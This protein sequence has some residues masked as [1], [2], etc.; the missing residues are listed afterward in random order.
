MTTL[1]K[2]LLFE[3]GTEELPP[4]SLARLA[5]ALADAIRQGL[6][7]QELEH[8]ECTWYATPRRL[9]VMVRD[10]AP[11]QADKHVTRRGPA[12]TAAYDEDGNP[13]K[14]AQGFARSCGVTAPE[15][16]RLDTDKGSWLAYRSL[17]QGAGVADLLP[18]IITKALAGLPIARRMRW[19]DHEVEFVRPVH[20]VVLLFGEDIIPAT[21]LGVAT[22]RET[23]GHRFHHPQALSLDN[24]GQ[25]LTR[26]RDE[27][28]VV[29]DF[30][31]R[32]HQ[33]RQAVTDIART[34]GGRAL[35][36]E[37]LLD[38]VTALV[39]WPVAVIGSFDAEFLNLPQEA[40]IA[41]MQSHQKYFPVQDPATGGLTASFITIANID[42]AD[43]DAVRRGNERV[44]RPRLS[45]A[46][47]FWER[48]RAR[49]QIHATSA[50]PV[51]VSQPPA[52]SDKAPLEYLG[53]TDKV[54]FQQQL[55]TL[56]DKTA[57][58]ASLG[59]YIA[60]QLGFAPDL[61]ARASR[62]AKCDLLSAMVGEFPELQGTM[63]RYYA[64][65]SGEPPAVAL[66]L[67]EQY[68]PR[69]A[70]AALPQTDTGRALALAD[71]LDTLTGIF[72][73]GKGP[74]GAKDPF[75]LRRAGLG[76]LRIMIECELPLDLERCLTH[77]ASAFPAAVKA[78]AV[79]ADVF[80]F[81]Q[82]RLR[83][84]YLDNGVAPGVFD[85]VQACRPT[86][87]HDFNL[88]VLAVGEFLRLPEAADLVSANKRIRNILKQAQF[89][90]QAGPDT[91]L[92]VEQTELAL[93]E[94]MRACQTQQ[95]SAGHDYIARLTAL[96]GLRDAVDAF[97]DKVMVLGEDAALRANR[98]ALLNGLRQLFLT[99]ADI[100]RLQ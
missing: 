76:C 41:S 13:T 19:G 58:I 91:A 6:S 90:E 25:Y 99:T 27:G 78:T 30:N 35:I 97:F 36:D 77:A 69:Y 11:A 16:T 49:L 55:G 38:E 50:A 62:L 40:L 94:K 86:Q 66:A 23:R 70:G 29:A 81:M 73:I 14:A 15:L 43:P 42:S 34:G 82:D 51:N 88:R 22:G 57:R 5:A 4:K 56:A 63:G 59:E 95:Q 1:K 96:A 84:Y 37:D 12:V 54:I 93:Y 9:A 39:E 18:G 60:R 20:W 26:L 32:K 46:A 98:L 79:T 17:V 72:A 83:R 80:D 64:E 3:T 10:L 7:E 48:D 61:V 74:T 85:A 33:I 52:P 21:V 2:D 53:E 8:G 67:Q 68:M 44:I 45:D 89:T 100:S 92:L 65:A 71:K 31:Q 87:P 28:R 75:G 47:F 24:P